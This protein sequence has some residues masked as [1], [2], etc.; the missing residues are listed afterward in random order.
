M[1]ALELLKTQH[2]EV[3]TLIG[4]I[5]KSQSTATRQRLFAELADKLAAHATIEER[6][7]YPAVMAKQTATL[8]LESVEEHLAIKR[9]LADMLELKSDDP[10]FEAK[11]SVMK[12]QIEHHAREEEEKALFPQVKK[13]LDKDEREA[14]GEELRVAFDGLV[15]MEPRTAV[16]AETERAAPL[17]P[18]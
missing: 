16:P 10:A 15:E 14:L 18:T 8:L 2:D 9:V 11:L 12:E 4:K 1:D 13:L 6:I 3:D 5:E 7:F 17:P